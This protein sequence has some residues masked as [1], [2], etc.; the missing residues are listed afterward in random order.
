[1]SSNSWREQ[2]GQYLLTNAYLGIP[3]LEA[4]AANFNTSSRSMQRKLRDEGVTYQEVADSVRKT[5]A[6]QYLAAGSHP[7]KEIS[8]ILG[9]NELSAFSRAFKRWTGAAPVQ[10]Q[11]Q[12]Q[13]R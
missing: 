2:V 6:L 3:S 10:Y 4:I 8:Y 1:M 12:T 7:V 13:L 9:Y 5:L 11:K